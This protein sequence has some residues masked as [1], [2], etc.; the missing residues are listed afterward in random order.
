MDKMVI[1]NG[2]IIQ[3]E[4][5]IY[6]YSVEISDIHV[7]VIRKNIYENFIPNILHKVT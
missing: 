1:S 5:F 7:D 2:N 6:I 4:M 3:Q